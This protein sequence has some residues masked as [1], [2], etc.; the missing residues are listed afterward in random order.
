MILRPLF[1]WRPLQVGDELQKIK[2]EH[3]FGNKIHGIIESVDKIIKLNENLNSGF[4]P[5]A[6]VNSI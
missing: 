6:R 4:G 2:K 5:N 3:L 1:Q